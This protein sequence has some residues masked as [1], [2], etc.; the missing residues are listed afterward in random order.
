MVTVVMSVPVAWFLRLWPTNCDCDDHRYLTLRQQYLWHA[1]GRDRRILLSAGKL[2]C[3]VASVDQ[4]SQAKVGP[5][6]T[7]LEVDL[8]LSRC[9]R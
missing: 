6:T 8:K 5:A 3:G 1:G 4:M 9:P 2:K 7:F